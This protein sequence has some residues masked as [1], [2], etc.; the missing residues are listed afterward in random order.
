MTFHNIHRR[1]NDLIKCAKCAFCDS[2]IQSDTTSK[3][4]FKFVSKF[5]RR[6]KLCILP[7]AS[8]AIELAERF[9]DYFI[10]KIQTIRVKID[11]FTCNL[12]SFS[13]ISFKGS[14]LCE[15]RLVSKDDVL[16]IISGSS[17]T[18]CSLDPLPT[19]L[20]VKNISSIIDSITILI[21]NS[22]LCG[23]VPSSFKHAVVNPLLKKNDL[24]PEIFK[25]YRPVCLCLTFVLYLKF[26]KR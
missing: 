15:F 8:T 3:A 26:L 10:D 20:L 16:K 21:N 5:Y 1:L 17:Q 4:L 2:F 22:L 13:T 25:N 12:Q 24:D 7:S 9:S 18:S 19:P 11:L 14:P 23:S 6:E